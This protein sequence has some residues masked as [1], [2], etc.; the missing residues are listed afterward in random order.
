MLHLT[1]ATVTLYHVTLKQRLLC[2]GAGGLCFLRQGVP[3]TA[4]KS[5]GMCAV[6]SLCTSLL[7]DEHMSVLST[8]RVCH[9]VCCA[10]VVRLYHNALH[11]AELEYVCF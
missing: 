8:I 9:V 7:V 3:L 2:T 4:C 6:T 1:V 11:D 10:H 5:S